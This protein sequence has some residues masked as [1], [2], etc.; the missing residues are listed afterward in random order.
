[1]YLDVITKIFDTGYANGNVITIIA[2]VITIVF[3][4]TAKPWREQIACK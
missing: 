2:L 4:P 3:A 1:M